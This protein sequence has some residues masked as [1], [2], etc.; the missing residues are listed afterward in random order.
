MIG[1]ILHLGFKDGDALT[2]PPAL[3]TLDGDEDD[4]EDEGRG[5]GDDNEA[6]KEITK[7]ALW[8]V[9]EMRFHDVSSYTRSKLIQSW[10][11]LCEYVV[12]LIRPLIR[13]RRWLFK[14]MH[15]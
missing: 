3:N 14:M 7:E 4:D 10:A 11:H 9:M 8:G 1:R 12:A 5:N 13:C 2:P 15:G 6:Q